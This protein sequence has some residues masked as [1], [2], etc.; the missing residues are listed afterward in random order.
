[1]DAPKPQGFNEFDQLM[2]KLVKP[3]KPKPPRM[4]SPCCGVESSVHD[5]PNGWQCGQCGKVWHAK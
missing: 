5:E 4:P 1:M 2:K 3:A